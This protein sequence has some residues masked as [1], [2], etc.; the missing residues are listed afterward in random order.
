MP[1][2]RLTQA[3]TGFVAILM[4]LT[5]ILSAVKFPIAW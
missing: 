5:L 4:V 1:G 3:V 2:T